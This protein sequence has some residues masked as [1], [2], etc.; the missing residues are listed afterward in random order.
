VISK[1]I[2]LL[3]ASAVGKT[4]LTRRF[5]E[6]EFSDRYLTTIGVKISKKELT[7]GGVEVRL[8]LWD[9]SGEDDYAELRMSYLRGAAGYFLVVDPTRKET[10][11]K[12]LDL[13]QRVRAEIG[14]QPRLL[15]LN[16][17]DLRDDWRIAAPETLADQTLETSAKT[18]S[19]VEEAFARLAQ[20]MLAAR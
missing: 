10:M 9:V 6:G 13:D 4:S 1:K 3:G 20:E 16:K 19:G 7:V 15:L 8:I 18:G 14:E 11:A 2:C 17:A 12:A 5:V